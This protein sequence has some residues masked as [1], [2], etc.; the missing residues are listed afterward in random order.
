MST[1][2]EVGNI[3]EITGLRYDATENADKL[4]DINGYAM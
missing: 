2:E 4:R 1:H 3:L